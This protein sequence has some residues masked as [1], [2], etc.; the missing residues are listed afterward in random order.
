MSFFPLKFR[1]DLLI[2]H[3]QHNPAEVTTLRDDIKGRVG[4]MTVI[5]GYLWVLTAVDWHGSG[6]GE[7][8]MSGMCNIYAKYTGF[9]P[10][11]LAKIIRDVYGKNPELHAHRL[12]NLYLTPDM[13]LPEFRPP[14]YAGS[15]AACFRPDSERK[16]GDL[17]PPYSLLAW[18]TD[19]QVATEDEFLS[20]LTSLKEWWEGSGFSYYI[21][22]RTL[23]LDDVWE[24][25]SNQDL[26]CALVNN[27]SIGRYC[28]YCKDHR[29]I[30]RFPGEFSDNGDL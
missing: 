18:L 6:S 24:V 3:L 21:H 23:I 29:T 27:S 9:A 13:L 12:I 1:A 8:T 25:P 2:R 22:S 26:V 20:L 19:I 5:D 15:Q 10:D 14:P 7:L 30:F 4:D 16:E 28:I 11:E 17:F